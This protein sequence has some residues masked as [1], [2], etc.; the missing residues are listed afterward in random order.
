MSGRRIRV[1][2][3]DD[4]RWYTGT[5]KSETRGR[6][7]FVEYDSLADEDDCS[8]WHKL[9]ECRHEFIGPSAPAATS[10]APERCESGAADREP[11]RFSPVDSPRPASKRLKTAASQGASRQPSPLAGEVVLV[12]AEPMQKYLKGCVICTMENGETV[13]DCD[14]GSTIAANL[15]RVDWRLAAE[16]A[17]E[18]GSS[19][20]PEGLSTLLAMGFARRDAESALCTCRF[21]G[22]AGSD[23]ERAT[24][25]LLDH[26]PCTSADAGS[27]TD[28]M[29][30]RPFDAHGLGSCPPSTAGGPSS[31]AE[32]PPCQLLALGD[33]PMAV[34]ADQVL[35][36]TLDGDGEAFR[37]TCRAAH[38]LCLAACRG[39]AQQL[40]VP[41]HISDRLGTAGQMLDF[42]QTALPTLLRPVVLR[43]L[44]EPGWRVRMAGVRAFSV[45]PGGVSHT[46]MELTPEEVL[47]FEE[48]RDGDAQERIR[49]MAK[50]LLQP[51]S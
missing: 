12:W 11:S 25:L 18:S 39:R 5:I 36:N 50:A 17:P 10:G 46:R 7:V 35:S 22:G 28:V 20:T 48:L 40:G 23:L 31:G 51:G 26:S 30:P 9:S 43:W 33:D 41:K 16:Q 37:A 44:K 4:R 21:N 1:Y 6:G 13:I 19:T 47:A 27:S 15:D 34:V 8:K 29:T 2:W 3:D 42:L 38:D 24:A 32:P 14:D 49:R 45:R